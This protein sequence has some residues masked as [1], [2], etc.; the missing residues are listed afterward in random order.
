MRGAMKLRGA[1][2]SIC[3]LLLTSLSGISARQTVPVVQQIVQKDVP[4]KM[5]DG[6]ILRADVLLPASEGKFPVLVYRTPYGKDSAPK[7]WTTFGKA[8]KR[9]YAVIIQDVRGRYTSEGEFDPYKNEGN[10]GYDT[11][12]WAAAQPWSNGDIGT[13]G[14][15]YPGAVQWLPAVVKTPPLENTV[16]RE[17]IFTARHFFLFGLSFHSSLV[18]CV[19]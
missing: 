18:Y 17:K 9:G 13:F 5:R 11:I 3:L 1:L 10:D 8:V 12:E 19:L 6:L 7:E 16:P 2:F 4:I 14:L 15:S